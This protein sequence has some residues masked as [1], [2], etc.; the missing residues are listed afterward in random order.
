MLQVKCAAMA[1]LHLLEA[2]GMAAGRQHLRLGPRAKAG[3]NKS[4]EPCTESTEVI[5]TGFLP[6]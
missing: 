4:T 2:W 5:I 6:S 3:E 1:K